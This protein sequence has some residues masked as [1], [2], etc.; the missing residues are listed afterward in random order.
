VV[1]VVGF[2]TTLLVYFPPINDRERKRDK[3]ER[4]R[5][6][7]EEEEERGDY[8]GLTTFLQ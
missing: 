2:I 1:V 6:E 4:E 3:R 7:E 5:E 8:F